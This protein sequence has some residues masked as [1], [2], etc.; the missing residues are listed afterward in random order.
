MFTH[1]AHR[2]SDA[3]HLVLAVLLCYVQRAGALGALTPRLGPL[4]SARSRAAC[5][6]HAHQ[7]Q[8]SRSNTL[9]RATTFLSPRPGSDVRARARPLP[10]LRFRCAWISPAAERLW[11]AAVLP[12]GAPATPSTIAGHR[13]SL[14]SGHHSSAA[15]RRAGCPRHPGRG[16]PIVSSRPAALGLSDAQRSHWHC[17]RAGPRQAAPM[18]YPSLPGPRCRGSGSKRATPARATSRRESRIMS[19]ESRLVS[20]SAPARRTRRAK[21][22]LPPH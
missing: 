8:P 13:G 4:P 9:P 22:A 17:A 5:A 2:A 18:S 19:I 3:S 12:H 6:R 7:S 21:R 15:V 11:L 14:D 20:A 16:V 1:A 10:R